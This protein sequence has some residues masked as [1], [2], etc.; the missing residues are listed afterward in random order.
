MKHKK[1]MTVIMTGMMTMSAFSGVLAAGIG[2]ID[3]GYLIQHHPKFQQANATWQA[4]LKSAQS[5]YIAKSKNAS[6]ADQDKQALSQQL[7]TTLSQQQRALFQPIEEDIVAKA[8]QVSTQKGLD[9]VVLKNAVVIGTP[10]DITQDVA[11]AL[12]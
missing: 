7:S 6:T 2:T 5:D 12:Q 4:D 3:M 11:Q 10:Q 9:A 8:Q 1:L